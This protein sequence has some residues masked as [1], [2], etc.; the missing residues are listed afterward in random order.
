[1]E[2]GGRGWACSEVGRGVGDNAGCYRGGR[3][4]SAAASASQMIFNT[5]HTAHDVS[6]TKTQG[7]THNAAHVT[8]TLRRSAKAACASAKRPREILN[9]CGVGGVRERLMRKRRGIWGCTG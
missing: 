4:M 7:V 1:M 9:G 6:V 3:G 8:C 2:G 5:L